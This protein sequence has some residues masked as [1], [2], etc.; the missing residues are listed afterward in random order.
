[1]A[2]SIRTIP[3]KVKLHQ[4]K[5]WQLI[6]L[7]HTLWLVST[8]DAPKPMAFPYFGRHF[9]WMAEGKWCA[10]ATKPLRAPLLS[11]SMVVVSKIW[12][13][14]QKVVGQT[15]QPFCWCRHLKSAFW[16]C[17]ISVFQFDKPSVLSKTYHPTPGIDWF[18]SLYVDAPPSFCFLQ[19]FSGVEGSKNF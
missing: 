14:T 1:M 8:C 3:G 16:V 12:P 19:W 6:L 17:A 9:K 15:L 18:D 4:D 13:H 7:G 10:K 2:W 5:S 11:A